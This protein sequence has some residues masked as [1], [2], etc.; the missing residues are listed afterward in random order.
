MPPKPQEGKQSGCLTAVVCMAACSV[1][2]IAARAV[3]WWSASRRTT[4]TRSSSS[5]RCNLSAPTTGSGS[6]EDVGV[7]LPDCV[8]AGLSQAHCLI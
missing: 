4:N 7:L 1:V 6:C 3:L 8:L 2:V 5:P